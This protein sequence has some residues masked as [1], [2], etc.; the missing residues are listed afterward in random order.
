MLEVGAHLGRRGRL[1]GCRAVAVTPKLLRIQILHEE[2]LEVG[3][4]VVLVYGDLRVLMVMAAS[5]LC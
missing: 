5:L 4:A 1:G 3:C 2:E